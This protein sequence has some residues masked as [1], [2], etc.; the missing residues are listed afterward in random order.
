MGEIMER[1]DL[2]LH[3]TENNSF[4]E[5]N[6]NMI[7]DFQKIN[8]V[9]RDSGIHDI[10]NKCNQNQNFARSFSN[11]EQVMFTSID[12]KPDLKD[13][14][15]KENKDSNNNNN[16]NNNKPS[17]IKPYASISDDCNEL[18]KKKQEKSNFMNRWNASVVDSID[19]QGSKKTCDVKD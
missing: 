19:F 9:Y 7:Q 4:V 6:E 18:F 15:V 14:T 13:N 11:S 1:V 10:T 8:K 16:N 3:Q 12:C 2:I 17:K 5:Q